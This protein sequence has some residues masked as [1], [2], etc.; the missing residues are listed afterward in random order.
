MR[1]AVGASDKQSIDGRN[2]RYIRSV[3]RRI[4]ER[5]NPVRIAEASNRSLLA[6]G[7]PEGANSVLARAQD[8]IYRHLQAPPEA[9]GAQQ[10]L[11][12][13]QIDL[14]LYIS[15][16]AKR[17]VGVVAEGNQTIGQQVGKRCREIRAYNHNLP[18]TIEPLGQP[19]DFVGIQ[20]RAHGLEIVRL[21]FK[22]MF[23]M[24]SDAAMLAGCGFH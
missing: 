8:C 3:E 12:S 16:R 13:K 19:N 2:R 21:D 4:D 14:L 6:I 24:I 9:D 23:N 10:I 17:S 18:G 11:G 22:A 1:L 15:C 5:S 7:D 20:L